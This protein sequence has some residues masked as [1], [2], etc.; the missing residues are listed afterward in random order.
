MFKAG[1]H[2]VFAAAMAAA[3]V[4][5]A[6][7]AAAQA[8][9]TW[10]SGVG[11][12]ANPCS[13]TAPCKTFPG[14]ISKTAAGGEINCID[15]GGFGAVTI[16][17]S[18][19]IDCDTTEA[20]VLVLG[21]NGITI[22]DGGAGTA[23]V[24]IRGIDF[25]GI[26]FSAGGTGIRG[27]S[28]VSGA[29]LLVDKSIIRNFRDATNGSGISFT[30]STAAKLTVTDTIIT[31]NGNTGAGA[32]I[33][34]QPTGSGT[35]VVVIDNTRILN[36]GNIGLSASSAG[37]SPGTT[38]YVSIKNST[39]SSGAYGV[40]VVV[41]PSTRNI[42]M[43]VSNSVIAQNTN[44]GLLS[45]GTGAQAWLDNNV[46]TSNA[47]GF[48]SAGGGAVLSYGGNVVFGN[49]TSNGTFTSTFTPQ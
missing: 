44:Y 37:A 22:N 47:D 19:T 12:D 36:S 15:P 49:T 29:S 27:I 16:T 39:I 20:G 13:R 6:A 26:G 33:L 24:V 46:I 14:A 45:N 41:P 35:A 25:E 4:G 9:R 28:F 8:T 18:I 1:K 2:L 21:T 10:V 30:P 32:G 43:T 31:G 38:T 5:Y 34:I 17:K 40:A 23:Q 48:K 42:Q 3:A 11:D 7:P